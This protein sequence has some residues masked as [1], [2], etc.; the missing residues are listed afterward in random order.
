MEITETEKQGFVRVTF[1]AVDVSKYAENYLFR[2]GRKVLLMSATI[3]N[4]G[5]FAKSLGIKEDDYDSISIASPF[6]AENRPII[7]ADVGSLSAKTIDMNLPKI[8]DAVKAILSE[9]KNEKGIIHT[10][11]YKIANYLKRE[12]RSKR[13]L[14]HDS[15]NREEVLQKHLNSKEPTVLLTPS[16]TEGVDLKGDASR[17]QIIV[18]VPYPYLGDTIV[19]KR[20]NKNEKWYPM[21]TAM[22]IVQAYGRSIRTFED[23]AITY[24][25]DSDWKRF[26]RDNSDVF[27]A[28]FDMCLVK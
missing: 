11:T 14:T 4:A 10:N 22:T 15:T 17:F 7:Q 9:H 18:K 1:R 27:P 8:K 3:L 13:I 19:R 24:I 21:Q 16:M 26:Y 6:P 5:G 20:M 12:L 28:G 2:M 23:H 25:L